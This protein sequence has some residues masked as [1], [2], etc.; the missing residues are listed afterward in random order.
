MAAFVPCFLGFFPFCVSPPASPA[1]CLAFAPLS[2]P[3]LSSLVDSARLGCLAC[4]G[5][6][7]CADLD[8]RLFAFSMILVDHPRFRILPSSSSRLSTRIDCLSIMLLAP[9]SHLSIPPP[10]GLSTV[11]GLS[12]PDLAISGSPLYSSPCAPPVCPS[13]AYST[14]T[15]S[16][17]SL[18]LPRQLLVSLAFL[19]LPHRT[20]GSCIPRLFVEARLI[21]CLI[22]CVIRD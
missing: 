20:H 10:T 21:R 1:F 3:P 17:N 9:I 6:P 16:P 7:A 15:P 12:G 22:P 11:P 14:D 5:Q 19:R 2:P 4:D 8:L 13:L 18:R